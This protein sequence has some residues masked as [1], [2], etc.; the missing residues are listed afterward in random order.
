MLEIRFHPGWRF[1][2]CAQVAQ[3]GLDQWC[4]RAGGGFGS[5]GGFEVGVQALSW[6][7]LGAVRGQVSIPRCG[8]G[9]RQATPSPAWRGAPCGCP[10]SKTPCAQYP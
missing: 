3:R 5:D 7:Q 10:A 9:E 8:R 6:I 4:L 1:V 2:E